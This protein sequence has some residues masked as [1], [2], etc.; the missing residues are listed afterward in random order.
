MRSAAR[1][2]ARMFPATQTQSVTATRS[3]LMPAA[4]ATAMATTRSW[5][6]RYMR[7]ATAIMLTTTDTTPTVRAVAGCVYSGV[8]RSRSSTPTPTIPAATLIDKVIATT[9]TRSGTLTMPLLLRGVRRSDRSD[10]RH[11]TR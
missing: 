6:D 9:A 3:E 11:P 7:F 4:I 8:R 5:G 10:T 2:S 1:E